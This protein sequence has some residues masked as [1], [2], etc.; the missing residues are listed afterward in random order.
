TTVTSAA[1][2]YMEPASPGKASST[3][4]I[5]DRVREACNLTA[6]QSIASAPKFAFDKS[7]IQQED[8]DV[9]AQVAQCLTSGPLKGQQV[10]LIGRADPRGTEE[11]NMALGARRSSSVMQYLEDSGVSTSQM[12]DTSR[13]ALDATGTGP[14]DWHLDRRVDI[15][16]GGQGQ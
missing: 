3:I 12:T 13:G 2:P 1:A 10:T 6:I 5:S 11:Y 14:H 7:D 16:L 9:L 8:S 4:Y 15:D